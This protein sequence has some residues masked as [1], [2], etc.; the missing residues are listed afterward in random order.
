M[1]CDPEKV[2]FFLRLRITREI[3]EKRGLKK[4]EIYISITKSDI[5]ICSSPPLE[6][7]PSL[8]D[9]NK[10][11][12]FKNSIFF[13]GW[14]E[15]LFVKGVSN[16]ESCWRITLVEENPLKDHISK[17]LMGQPHEMDHDSSYDIF[18]LKITND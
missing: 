7:Y 13:Q 18:L 4:I 5:I 2:K 6:L 14:A 1:I 17:I 11:L 12:K 8:S 3:E 10:F 9:G 16:E 15:S